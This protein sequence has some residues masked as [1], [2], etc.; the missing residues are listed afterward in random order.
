MQALVDRMRQLEHAVHDAGALR[1][2]EFPGG[3]AY[4]NDELPLV[5]DVNFVRIDRETP[6]LVQTIE[7]LQAG[8]GHHKVLI[9]DPALVELHAP[10]LI[11]RGFTRRGLVAL[12]REP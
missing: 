3:V 10:E 8:Q 11:G 12:A 1:R 6:N 4:F 5:W 2:E 9:E 7:H